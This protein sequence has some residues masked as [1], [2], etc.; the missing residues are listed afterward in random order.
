MISA[1]PSLSI[2]SLSRHHS[3]PTGVESFLEEYAAAYTFYGAGKVALRD[4][5]A[6]LVE[7]GQNVL[8]PAYLP[9]AVVEP[10]QELGLEPRYYRVEPS[11]APDLADVEQR[12]DA[13]TA[14]V[15]SVNY[16]GFP[17]PGLEELQQLIEDYNC[18]HIDDN[19]HAPLSIDNGTLLGTRGHI[20]I[21]SLWK[22]LPVPNGA[23]L[24][25]NDAE[26]IEN[27]QP[28]PIAGVRES[29]DVSDC[30]F[31]VKSVIQ[32]LLDGNGM[33]R[34]SLDSMFAL[35][36]DETPAVGGPHKRYEDG[37]RMMSRLT[38]HILEESNPDE[39]RNRR[40]TNYRTWQRLLNDRDDLEFVYD[41]LPHGICPQALP[42]RA[43]EPKKLMAALQR[44]GAGGAYNWPR[45]STTVLENPTYETATRLSKEIVALPVHQHVDASTIEAVA[46][47]LRH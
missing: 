22:L 38:E 46:M 21:T 28:S 39:I 10:F 13:N 23:V 40:R 7:P 27:F 34:E 42:V 47:R 11:F 6:G 8:L 14:A 41:S 3:G 9:D 29:V 1:G 5:L 15:M 44:C 31:I 20:G 18:Y 2:R 35:D 25:H 4:G 37:K 45:L 12:I 16:F 24:F 17:Q 30:Q 33:I 43:E 36:D 26:T 19:A 32:N